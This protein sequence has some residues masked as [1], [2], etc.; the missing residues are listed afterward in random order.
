MIVEILEPII[1]FYGNPF[2]RFDWEESY[3]NQKKYLQV[4][5]RIKCSDILSIE[6]LRI[7]DIRKRSEI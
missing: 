2:F 3:V 6:I 1:T 7:R 5:G 4:L